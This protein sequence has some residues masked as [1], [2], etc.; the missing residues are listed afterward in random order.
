MLS[1]AA[2]CSFQQDQ[3][4]FIARNAMR[5]RMLESIRMQGRVGILTPFFN[6]GLFEQSRPLLLDPAAEWPRYVEKTRVSDALAQKQPEEQ[7]S[8]L[9]WQCATFDLWRRRYFR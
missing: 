9:I 2:Y 4:E 3:F 7:S 6:F 8:L 1:L 5:K